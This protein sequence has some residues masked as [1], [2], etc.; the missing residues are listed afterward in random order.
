MVDSVVGIEVF[1]LVATVDVLY[2]FDDVGS[3]ELLSALSF[4]IPMAFHHKQTRG[5]NAM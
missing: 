3:T 5:K 2:I 1:L 4:R